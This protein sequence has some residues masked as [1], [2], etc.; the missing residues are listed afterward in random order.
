MNRIEIM[1][2]ASLLKLRVAT[3]GRH[4][5]A[6]RGEMMTGKLPPMGGG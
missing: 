4:G 2:S 5:A 1:S 3:C 6:W